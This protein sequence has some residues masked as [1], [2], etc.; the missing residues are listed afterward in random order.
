MGESGLMEHIQG[1]NLPSGFTFD[2]IVRIMDTDSDGKVS[3]YEFTD[4]M[5]NLYS[6]NEFQRHCVVLSH[7][8]DLKYEIK[9]VKEALLSAQLS[10]DVV[11]Q[12]SFFASNVTDDT[13]ATCLS[14]KAQ[15]R[16]K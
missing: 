13:P 10:T 16:G 12:D 11:C 7:L 8:A 9:L 1:L 14:A 5:R 3:E 2:D 6:P 4:G 15:S